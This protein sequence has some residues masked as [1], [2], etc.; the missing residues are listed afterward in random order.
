MAPTTYF[1]FEAPT[2]PRARA[3]A[4]TGAAR[5]GLSGAARGAPGESEPRA[6]LR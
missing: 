2:G 6:A 4:D 1:K 3:A 5:Q